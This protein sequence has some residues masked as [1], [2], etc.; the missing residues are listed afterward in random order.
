MA[1]EVAIG[2]ASGEDFNL[3]ARGWLASFPFPHSFLLAMVAL[4]K[5]T[6]EKI[7]DEIINS[8][9]IFNFKIKK[10]LK[11]ACHLANICFKAMFST[12]F[13][14]IYFLDLQSIRN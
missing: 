7:R 10:T 13:F 6:S 8:F 9:N 3:M 12:S 14:K 2:V 5:F 1:N 4:Q 11:M